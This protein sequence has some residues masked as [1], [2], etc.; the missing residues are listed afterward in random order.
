MKNFCAFIL[1]VI[2]LGFSIGATLNHHYCMGKFAGTSLFDLD[3]NKCDK[4]GME[5]GV[6]ES[7]GCCTDISF[8]IKASE[9]HT[10][11]QTV[12]DFRFLAYIISATQFITASIYG[13]I[14]QTENVFRPQGP[15]LQKNPLFI[16]FRNFRV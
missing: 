4:C 14:A 1:A 13:Q 15:P 8:V 16:Q 7:K 6:G 10:F 5:E 2:Y 11:T 12:Y 9:S 3:E